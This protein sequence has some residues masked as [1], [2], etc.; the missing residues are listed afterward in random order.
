[1]GLYM[2]IG[3]CRVLNVKII[4]EETKELLYEG[5]VENAPDEIKAMQYKSVDV[6]NQ[7]IFYV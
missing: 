5:M 6:G 7:T 2:S 1:M 4:N 3:V